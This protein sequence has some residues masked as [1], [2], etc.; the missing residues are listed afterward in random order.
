MFFLFCWAFV[1]DGALMFGF[2]TFYLAQEVVFGFSNGS[3]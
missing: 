1:S 3:V 2:S